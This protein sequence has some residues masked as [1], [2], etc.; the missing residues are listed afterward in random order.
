MHDRVSV[1][2]TNDLCVCVYILYLFV[3]DDTGVCV[4]R[5]TS[6]AHGVIDTGSCCCCVTVACALMACV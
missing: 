5:A 6:D 1:I 2:N 3:Y 4:Y